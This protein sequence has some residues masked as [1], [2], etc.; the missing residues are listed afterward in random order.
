M[1]LAHIVLS[2]KLYEGNR[3]L[4][5]MHTRLV[6]R[7]SGGGCWGLRL[8]MRWMV[9]KWDGSAKAREGHCWNCRRLILLSVSVFIAMSAL[10]K[11]AIA[12]TRSTHLSQASPIICILN[13]ARQRFLTWTALQSV[14]WLVQYL[15]HGFAVAR[16]SCHQTLV[17]SLLQ[18]RCVCRRLLAF[19][20]VRRYSG[21]Q[22]A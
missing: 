22:L 2:D 3:W 16:Q 7:C 12:H 5:H 20:A 10:D 6:C 4:A 14:R 17:A 15:Q 19:T 21:R 13:W 1:S 18:S 9:L 8:K 11:T